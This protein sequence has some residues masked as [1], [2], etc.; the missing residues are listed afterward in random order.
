MSEEELIRCCMGALELFVN[1]G[2]IKKDYPDKYNNAIGAIA[3][4]RLFFEQPT[5]FTE[6]EKQEVSDL[7]K[8]LFEIEFA[9]YKAKK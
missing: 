1:N 3:D 5:P 7:S 6:K 4:C 2:Q 8:V 9:K